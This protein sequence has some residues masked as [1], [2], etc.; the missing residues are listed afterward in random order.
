[1]SQ[2]YHKV[3]CMLCLYWR[4]DSFHFLFELFNMRLLYFV[5]IHCYANVSVGSFNQSW[6]VFLNILGDSSDEEGLGLPTTNVGDAPLIICARA[7]L[8][9]VPS[10][11]LLNQC[12][13][14]CLRY[15]H[16]IVGTSA[17]QNFIQRMVSK[18][19][20]KSFPLIYLLGMLYPRHFMWNQDYVQVQFWVCPLFGL[21]LLKSIL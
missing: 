14:T 4:H 15:N 12:G 1:M 6:Y 19:Y 11:V 16:R 18:V 9:S 8:N 13:V 2:L 20:G 10:H 17:Q 5:M 7:E 21:T 3:V